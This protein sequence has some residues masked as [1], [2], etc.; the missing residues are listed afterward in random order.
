MK[1]FSLISII[2]AVFLLSHSVNAQTTTGGNGEKI[3]YIKIAKCLR[4]DD[5]IISLPNPKYPKYVGFGPHVYNGEVAVQVFIDETGNTEKANGVS[6]HPFFRP[7]LEKQ[8]MTATFKPKI[9]NGRPQK[10]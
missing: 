4:C 7:L 2:L 9:V 10:Y 5:L 1:T 8:L 3:P 6:G